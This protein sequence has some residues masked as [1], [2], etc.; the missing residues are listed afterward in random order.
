[1]ASDGILGA[2]LLVGDPTP[3]MDRAGSACRALDTEGIRR[4]ADTAGIDRV[5][6]AWLPGW[7]I[8][9]GE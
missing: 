8:H 5:S 3:G 7:R 6:P 9:G 1:M 2:V 4:P